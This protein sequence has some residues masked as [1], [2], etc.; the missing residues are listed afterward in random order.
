ME[1]ETDSLQYLKSQVEVRINN[2]N[3]LRLR[4]R[5]RAFI[6][7][8][9]ISTLAALSSII[10]GLNFSCLGEGPRIVALIISGIIAVISA[11]NAF[12]D[13]KQMWVAF[14]D[15]L[16][17]FYKLRFD[18]EFAEKS[19]EIN[20]EALQHFKQGYQAIL[21]SLNNKWTKLREE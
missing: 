15:A 10:L 4:Y 6:T 17:G 12:F 16:N 18:I 8:L 9:S 19:N 7:A 2:F 3:R 11:Y 5:K 14:N 20:E 1:T 13:N 21:D